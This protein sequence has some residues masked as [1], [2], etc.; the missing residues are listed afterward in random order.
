MRPTAV[1]SQSV[2]PKPPPTPHRLPILMTT[3]ESTGLPPPLWGT[4]PGLTARLVRFFQA[5]RRGLAMITLAVVALAP[6]VFIFGHID[7]ARR[8][9]VYWDEI[10]TALAFILKLKDGVAPVEFLQ[11]LFAINNEHRMVTSR[12]LFAASY[13]LSGTIN[14][15]W[16]ELAGNATVVALCLLLVVGAG[17]SARRL[18]LGVLLACFVFQL[19][20]YENF[21][22]SGSSIDHFQ[23][24]LLAAGALVALTRESRAATLAATLLAILATFTL[25]HGLAVWPVGALSLALAGRRRDLAIWGA[26]GVLA[27][28]GFFAGFTVNSAQSFTAFSPAGA[29]RVLHY[30]LSILGAAPALGYAAAAPILG[31][32][33]LLTVAF[34]VWRGAGRRDPVALPLTAFAVLA[35]GMIA[36]GRAEHSA[37]QVFSR[38]YILSALAWA[39]ALYIILNRFSHPRRPLALLAALLPLLLA[40]NVVANL[41]F[42]DETDSWLNCRDIAAVNY[43]QYGVDGRGPFKLHP[44]PTRATALLRQAESLGVYQMGPVCLPV[45]FP[46]RAKVTPQ[47]KYFIEEISTSTGAAAVRGWAAIPGQTQSRGSIHLVLRSNEATHVFTTVTIPRDDVPAAM[48][49]PGW[50]NAGFHFARRLAKM[51]VGDFQVG[52]LLSDDE[53]EHYIMTGHRLVIYG[54]AGE[55]AS[56]DSN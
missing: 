11:E 24:V 55:F 9:L 30:W 31:G 21:L 38:Y 50:T 44:M 22:W 8:D 14:F 54:S 6:A 56:V 47:I 34:A 2:P 5:H 35:A 49:E 1:E 25:A 18:R 48:N 28:A 29:A 7:E 32:G 17:T 45:P 26:I 36:F 23:V 51:P 16:V 41:Q 53:D 20:H 40:F 42:A 27:A 43:K 52:L 37:G 12:L 46:A 19:E 4:R 39:L 15:A 10:D 3:Y 13:W 33:L